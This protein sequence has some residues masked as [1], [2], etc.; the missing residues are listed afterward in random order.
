M[1]TGI[2]AKLKWLTRLKTPSESSVPVLV[3]EKKPGWLTPQSAEELLATPLRQRL[4][5]IIW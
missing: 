5:Q 3:Q 2:H 1:K 4:M